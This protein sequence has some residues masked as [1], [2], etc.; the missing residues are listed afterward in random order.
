MFT[1][2]FL[3]TASGKP[4]PKRAPSSILL[5]KG[6]SAYLYD[7]GEG[8]AQSLVRYEGTCN[9]IKD[10]FISHLHPDHFSGLAYLIQGMHLEKREEP[11]EVFIPRYA[12][13]YM[14]AYLQINLL[15]KRRLG[16]QVRFMP[17]KEGAFFKDENLEV[18]AIRTRHLDSL[19]TE[20]ADTLE[21]KLDSFAF[22]IRT[23][24][25]TICYSSD[26]FSLEDINSIDGG[27]II[28]LDG[29]H[30]PL[31]EIPLFIKTHPYERIFLTHIPPEREYLTEKDSYRWVWAYDGLQ[32]EVR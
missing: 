30:F 29:M 25:K 12:M 5:K 32:I 22:V 24:N 13:Q 3:G 1:C 18:S 11:L 7:C 31:E 20:L 26:L 23:D 15:F 8:T 17:I 4:S 16:F 28:I 19:N 27:D 2:R 10:I 14:D 9:S 6:S 21:N